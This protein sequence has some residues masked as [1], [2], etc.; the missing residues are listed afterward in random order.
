MN[1]KLLKLSSYLL[2][3]VGLFCI[4]ISTIWMMLCIFIPSAPN[5]W[6]G[7]GKFV[8]I[9]GFV[10]ICILNSPLII[11]AIG[12]IRYLKCKKTYRLCIISDIIGI[13]LF[14]LFIIVFIYLDV[15]E[16]FS[17]FVTGVVNIKLQIILSV[18][19]FFIFVV[20][21][22]TNMVELIKYKK[23]LTFKMVWKYYLIVI[24]AFCLIAFGIISYILYKSY[25]INMNKIKVT[26]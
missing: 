11:S 2:L 18:I 23:K 15:L 14:S 1:K 25:I 21:L 20:P 24:V 5:S 16:V 19:I 4:L 7:L 8:G 12:T 26:E 6:D 10:I 22:I 9:V 17:D 3:T 13:I